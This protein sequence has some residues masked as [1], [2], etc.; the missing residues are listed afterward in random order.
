MLMDGTTRTLNRRLERALRSITIAAIII[1]ILV[2]LSVLTWSDPWGPH[3]P[4][5]HIL[6]LDALA[7]WEG[8]APQEEGWPGS[9]SVL[10]LSAASAV[11][12]WA[13]EGSKVFRVRTEPQPA[14]EDVTD[15]IGNRFVNP[16]ANYRLG[17]SVSL[18]MGI[19]QL[20]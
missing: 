8:I 16:Q 3:H 18:I 1:G 14:L 15:W 9:T 12:Y 4:D 17:R 5:E 11:Q 19:L 2:R 20:V 10:V 7:L 13:H 6:P